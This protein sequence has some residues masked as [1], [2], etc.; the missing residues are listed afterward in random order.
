MKKMAAKVVIQA[1]PRN[2][3][4]KQVKT[5]RREGKLP[6]VIYG[7]KIDPFSVT[8]DLHETTL[9]LVN[10]TSTSLVTVA[11]E[12]KEYATLIREKQID[13]IKGTLRHIDFQVVSLTEKIRANVAVELVGTSPAVKD[14]NGFIA[15]ELNELEVEALPQD[16]PEKFIIDIS[17]LKNIG[18]S[19]TVK[20]IQ[21]TGNVEIFNEPEEIVVVV[22][23][24]SSSEEEVS[25]EEVSE[26]EEAEPEVI[27]RG[28]KVEDFED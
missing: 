4:G 27:E 14:F 17:I 22:T 19:I 23:S 25:E 7:H 21:T 11:I 15:T 26:A 2:I 6:A 13:Y 16:L 24:S 12:G 20:D 8:L 1:T 5:L 9:A 10:L 18:D 28:K 3:I